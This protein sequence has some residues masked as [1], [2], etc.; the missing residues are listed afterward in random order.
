MKTLITLY[1][2]GD[3]VCK[4]CPEVLQPLFSEFPDA[5]LIIETDDQACDFGY[6]YHP[7]ARRI[8]IHELNCTVE[9]GPDEYM[10]HICVP[11]ATTS[12][13]DLDSWEFRSLEVIAK[14]MLLPNLSCVLKL[15][16]GA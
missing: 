13:H 10:A 9:L 1:R 6:L 7:D 8:N 12:Q 11:H 2:K 14:L 4:L 16:K 15:H 3:A 5:Q